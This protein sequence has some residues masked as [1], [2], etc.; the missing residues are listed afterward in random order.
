MKEALATSKASPS[1]AHHG[2]AQSQPPSFVSFL[3]SPLFN[4]KVQLFLLTLAGIVLLCLLPWIA[5]WFY[6][7]AN[8]TTLFMEPPPPGTD[9][10]TTHPW[11]LVAPKIIH[12]RWND[13]NIPEKWVA[14]RERCMAMHPDYEF[15]LWTEAK[16][17]ALL[18]E[19][20]PWFLKTYDHYRY[21]IQ[22]ADIGRY[23]FMH[24]YGGLY[25]DLDVECLKRVDYLLTHEIVLP[26]TW[27]VGFSNDVLVAPAGHPFYDQVCGCGGGGEDD[28]S[29]VSQP[30][31]W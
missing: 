23:F 3:A 10:S 17:R 8:P 20:Y 28:N 30:D 19:R 16:E 14:V 24:T 2:A 13:E 7:D 18:K 4:R 22:Q 11:P 27:P 12:H 5:P 29:M 1:N 6:W 9:N 26:L 25:L 15:M 31:T 21:T